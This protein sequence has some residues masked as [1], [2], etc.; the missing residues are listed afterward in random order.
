MLSTYQYEFYTET[1]KLQCFWFFLLQVILSLLTF[2]CK[3]RDGLPSQAEE[4]SIV[5]SL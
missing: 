5:Q 1:L 4:S 2:V 3:N